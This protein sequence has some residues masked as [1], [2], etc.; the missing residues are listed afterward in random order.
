M[1]RWFRLTAFRVC[2]FLTVLSAILLTSAPPRLFA[3]D[4]AAID[5]PSG[6]DKVAVYQGTWKLTVEHL[7]TPFGKASHEETNLRND[8]WRSAA[9][10]ACNQFVDGDSKALLVFTYDAKSDAFR[11]HITLPDGTDA[12]GGKLLIKGNVWTF[13]WE[14]TENGK[15]THFRILNTFTSN[16]AIEF[17]QEYSTDGEHWTVMARGSETRVE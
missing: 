12:G 2:A 6:L 10:Y 14:S 16:D 17:R 1:R 11:S 3:A 7:E 15:T 4:A 8:C 13:P 9:F 5:K